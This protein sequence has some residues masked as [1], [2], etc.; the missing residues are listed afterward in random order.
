MLALSSPVIKATKFSK[1][2]ASQA[3]I[4]GVHNFDLAAAMLFMMASLIRKPSHFFLCTQACNRQ[5]AYCV[6]LYDS[7]GEDAIEYIVDHASCSIIFVA[8]LKFPGLIG[9]LPRLKHL[10]KTV[11]YWGQSDQ[12]SVQVPV[13]NPEM[14]PCC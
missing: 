2:C 5:S 1:Q 13:L 3:E 6:P 7:L 10:V 14:D 11:V 4:P 12:I 9:A 8:S